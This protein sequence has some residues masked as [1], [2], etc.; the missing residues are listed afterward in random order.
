MEVVWLGLTRRI[1]MSNLKLY[2]AVLDEFPDYMAPTLVA[3]AVLAADREFAGIKLY[4]QWFAD[5]FKKVVVRVNQKEFDKIS[6]LFDVHL[7]HENKTL[8]GKKAC[9]VVCPREDMP[10]VLKFAKTWK[11][12]PTS[13]EVS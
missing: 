11:P 7:A 4:E 9:A 12:L 1:E 2:I 3:H 10:N 6:Q 5:S 13:S 8:G